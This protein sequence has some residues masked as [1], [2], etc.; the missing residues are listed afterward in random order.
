MLYQL[1]ETDL[2]NPNTSHILK[3]SKLLIKIKDITFQSAFF[4]SLRSS[5][6]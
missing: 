5:I 1:V 3:A 6:S 4:Q 2:N